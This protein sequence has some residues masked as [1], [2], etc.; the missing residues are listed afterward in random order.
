MITPADRSATIVDEM[1]S[2]PGVV[3]VR[4]MR[5]FKSSLN[6]ATQLMNAPAA[7]AAVGGI[8]N[9]GMGIKIGILD[10]GIDQTHPAFQDP[11]LPMPAGFP[12]CTTGHPEDCAYT[13]NKVIV[14]RS[15]VRLLSAGSSPSNPA[16]DDLP[17][18]YSPRDRQ[19]HGTGVASAAAGVPISGSTVSSTGGP[20]IIQ[21]M[22][23]KAYLGN[24]KIAG[25]P[26]VAE[27]ASDQTLIQAV[28]DAVADGMD[29]ISTSW[30]S[31]AISDAASDPVSAAFEAAALAGA[32]VTVA[33]GNNNENGFQ[34]PAFN[35][36]SSPSNAPDVISVGGTENSHVF[37]PS[38]SVSAPGAPSN[39]KGI[40]AQPSDTFN[41]PS[42]QGM[43]ATRAP[44][45]DITQLGDN[46][47]AC[48]NLPAYSLDGGILLLIE[49]GT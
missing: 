9:A 28:E 27:G 37:L 41:Y 40:P 38:V 15:Y 13:N 8:G 16:V 5:R 11:S 10:S 36:I 12:K 3:A 7:W 46:G 17:D 23:P 45:I 14:A 44:L 2:I 35:S 39:L 21:G 31:A 43:A 18:D 33:A 32:V 29:V 1:K 19:G 25:S 24:Y 22:A 42:S 30:G 48:N 49:R 20:V 47:L 26:G 6:R 34:Y 4:P